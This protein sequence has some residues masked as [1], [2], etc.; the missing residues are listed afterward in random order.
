MAETESTSKKIWTG[1]ATGVLVILITS[2]I[3]WLRENVLI[4]CGKALWRF[5]A[6]VGHHL[7]S[8]ATIPW[9]FLWILIVLSAVVLL[10]IAGSLLHGKS[11]AAKE[12]EALDW[13]NFTELDYK[14]VK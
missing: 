1:T 8:S 13:H 7:I 12:P 6:S 2:L 3:P 9:W 11:K 5:C 4:P 14:G 10:R